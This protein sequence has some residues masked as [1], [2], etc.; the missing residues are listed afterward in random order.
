MSDQPRDDLPP[1]AGFRA[2]ASHLLRAAM[3]VG[4]LVM[5]CLSPWAFGA[6]GVEFEA[7]LYAGIAALLGLWSLR[8]LLE[9]QLSWKQ[10]PVLMV[11]TVL[12]LCGAWQLA[13]LTNG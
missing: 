6:A 2:S 7:V 5:V 1:H 3:E 12:V 8:I 4:V 13:P 11:L 9:W 10:C